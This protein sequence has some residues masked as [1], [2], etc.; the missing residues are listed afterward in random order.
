MDK[1]CFG[2]TTVLNFVLGLLTILDSG[3]TASV[4]NKDD[5]FNIN[6]TMPNFNST[7]EDQYTFL[8]YE[9]PDEELAIVGYSPLINMNA[10]HHMLTFAC[11]NPGSNKQI[12]TSGQACNGDEQLII[13]GWARNA[14]SMT[15]P[16]D[17]GFPVGRNTPYKYIVV[18]IHYLSS[19]VNDKSGNQLIISRK[20]R[21]Y[22]AGVM[23]AGTSQI[24]IKP[25]THSIRTPFSCRYNGPS[26]S[27]FAARV[28]AHQWA[29]VNSLYRVRDGV[30]TQIV[31]GDPQWPQSFYPLPSP[32]E[33]QNDDYLVGQCVYDN[34][35]D[36]IVRVGPTHKDEMCNIYAMYSFEPTKTASG[37]QKTGAAPIRSCWDNEF[38][39]LI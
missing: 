10:A 29:R 12:W 13:H 35:D 23:L 38:S 6:I 28:H 25:K 2:M 11:A 1:Y 36:H 37:K 3:Y 22:Q 19:I 30:I 15:L 5:F 8:Q 39:S 17:V 26:I 18:N 14:P 16:D 9:L 21:K 4:R 34:D 27:I 20:P 24:F 33:I 31:K 7:Q 32:I